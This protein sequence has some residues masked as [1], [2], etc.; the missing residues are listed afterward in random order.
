V[1][2]KGEKEY[3]ENY[4]PISLLSIVS[5]VLGRCMH[6]S[7][8]TD[9]GGVAVPGNREVNIPRFRCTGTSSMILVSNIFVDVCTF[10]RN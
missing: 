3:A 1:Y 4:R 10:T 6:A 7:F 5:N 9:L 2:K 8:I